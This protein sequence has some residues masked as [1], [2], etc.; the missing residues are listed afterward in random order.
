M[1]SSGTIKNF[2]V[3]PCPGCFENSLLE[4]SERPGNPVFFGNGDFTL[5]RLLDALTRIIPG[6]K[7]MLSVYYLHSSTLATL[8]T[9]LFRDRISEATVIYDVTETDLAY[10]KEI[11]CVSYPVRAC[12]LSI[13]GEK[14]NITLAG[15]FTQGDA[16]GSL[17]CFTMI[18]DTEQQQQIR[19]LLKQKKER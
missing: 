13:Q 4:L 9:L 8:A 14:K 17:E 5:S 2:Y 11:T 3:E 10:F 7:V 16:S 15:N 1:G 18:N 6:G 19:R 12:I